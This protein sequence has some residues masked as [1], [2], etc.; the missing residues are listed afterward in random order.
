MYSIRKRTLKVLIHLNLMIIFLLSFAIVKIPL[1]FVS[2]LQTVSNVS[3]SLYQKKLF[4]YMTVIFLEI[5]YS[6]IQI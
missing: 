1:W 2:N 4:S 6:S 5:K 3:C